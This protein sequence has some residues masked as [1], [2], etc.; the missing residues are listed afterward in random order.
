MEGGKTA[1]MGSGSRGLGHQTGQVVPVHPLGDVIA[2]GGTPSP[3]HGDL[4]DL[5]CDGNE[6]LLLAIGEKAVEVP[7]PIGEGVAAHQ[8]GQG[9]AGEILV[10]GLGIGEGVGALGRV[11]VGAVQV[12][13]VHGHGAGG[14][15]GVEHLGPGGGGVGQRAPAP[16]HGQHK[17]DHPHRNRPAGGDGGGEHL[18]EAAAQGGGGGGQTGGEPPGVPGG[19]EQQG[20]IL[21][22]L[23]SVGEEEHRLIA[24]ELQVLGAGFHGQPHHRVE[25]AHGG[26]EQQEELVPAVLPGQMDHLVAQHPVQFLHGVGAGREHHPGGAGDEAHGQGGVHRRGHHQPVF[27]TAEVRLGQ[28]FLPDFQGLGVGDGEGRGQN[29]AAE[30]EV[31][32][33]VP[34]QHPQ[35]ARQPHPQGHHMPPARNHQHP[36]GLGRTVDGGA[37]KV[38]QVGD[39]PQQGTGA[40]ADAAPEQREHQQQRQMVEADVEK[41]PH[42]GGQGFLCRPGEPHQGQG[43]QQDGDAQGQQVGG[44][45]GQIGGTSAQAGQTVVAK[46]GVVPEKD[47]SGQEQGPQGKDQG[48]QHPQSPSFSSSRS[49]CSSSLLSPLSHRA[50]ANTDRLPPQSLSKKRL[51]WAAR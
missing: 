33:D 34:P 46:P 28:G 29:A 4:H 13:P 48:T 35:K 49:S 39:D 5:V 19:V 10:E 12:H 23:G 20:G 15:G 44:V 18:P 8:M 38:Q 2:V 50:E 42:I 6:P 47:Q 45:V 40:G 30:A 21:F 9:Q 1:G 32:G 31:P 27:G 17:E 36:Q 22:A 41:Q 51:L 25:P 11:G 7:L 16:G 14:L 24:A 43:G 3:Q 26:A 37:G